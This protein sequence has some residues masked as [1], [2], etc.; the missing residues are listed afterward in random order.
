[1]KIRKTKGI[2][3]VVMIAAIGTMVLAAPLKASTGVGK[4]AAIQASELVVQGAQVEQI[5][6]PNCFAGITEITAIEA[7]KITT[8][9]ITEP[10]I[11]K[12]EIARA[13]ITDAQ[14]AIQPYTVAACD[15]TASQKA[16]AIPI[17]VAS[18]HQTGFGAIRAATVAL[19]GTA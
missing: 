4:E 8:A 14:P 10:A 17:Y 3:A 2:L 15:R 7:A 18:A 6:G 19:P 13:M 5:A 9:K 12:D 1:M 16:L 11:M